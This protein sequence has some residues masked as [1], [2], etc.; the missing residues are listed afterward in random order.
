MFDSVL[1]A[2]SLMEL[3]KV[4]IYS[5]LFSPIVAYT[6]I[7]SAIISAKT[8]SW[9]N[10]ALSDLGIPDPWNNYMVPLLFN[11]GLI[12][13]GL[14]FSL[15][16][17]GFILSRKSLL[18]KV[19]GVFLFLDAISLMFIG[20]FPEN[21]FEWHFFFSVMF[22][23]L[24]PIT[25]MILTAEFYVNMKNIDLA[26]I[27]IILAISVI[28]I[29]SVPWRNMGVTGVALPEFLSSLCGSIW[30]YSVIWKLKNNY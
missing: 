15:F 10:N 16:A 27:S 21:I 5:G 8:F 7:F 25:L 12:I 23:T 17:I 20:V 28:I 29:W 30:L 3:K 11:T 24:L 13:S 26:L 6:F 22:F 19:G 2:V 4:L 1:T 14:L 18:G 9:T